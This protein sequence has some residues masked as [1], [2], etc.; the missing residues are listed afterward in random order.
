MPDLLSSQVRAIGEHYVIAR[1]ISYGFIAGLAPE[2]TKNI[3]IIAISED[4]K[5]NLQI[6]VKTRTIG[7]SSDK[8]WH[9]QE[10]HESIIKDNLFY[11]FVAIPLTW[12]D[13]NQPETFIIP[14]KKVASILRKSHE[15]WLKTPGVKGQKRQNTK[16]RRI[17]PYYKDS[18]SI[19]GNW[20][21]E[22]KDNR[23]FLK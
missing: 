13:H 19:S 7:R 17:L 12:T 6:K 20:M 15:D 5:T 4:G 22:F 8:G 11:V 14:S 3:D 23:K 2:N 9:M 21:E 10:K 16:M 18:P 1:L